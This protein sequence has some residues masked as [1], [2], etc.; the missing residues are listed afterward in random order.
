MVNIAAFASRQFRA[1]VIDRTGLTGTYRYD[2]YFGPDV[3]QDVS[4]PE[5]PNFTTAA[6]EQLGLRFERTRGTVDILVIEQVHVLL[7]N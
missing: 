3:P 7:E 1:P 4:N 2:V 5:L 6:R